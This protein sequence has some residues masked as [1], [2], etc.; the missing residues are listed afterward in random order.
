ML[1]TTYL[2]KWGYLK[3]SPSPVIARQWL[4]PQAIC[5]ILSPFSTLIGCGINRS[6]EFPCPSLPKSPLKIIK[7]PWV[8]PRFKSIENPGSR[9]LAWSAF[10]QKTNS[11][12]RKT[13]QLCCWFTP[14]NIKENE[15]ARK[16]NRRTRRNL[17][18]KKWGNT[19]KVRKGKML[20]KK[21]RREREEQQD[22][23][24]W[25]QDL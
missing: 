22:K 11:S 25:E 9:R 15:K 5:R 21:G 24:L 23:E 4:S 18:K 2:G 8:Q 3:T 13:T 16:P 1:R 10:S 19:R 14:Q 12:N 17:K 20:D 7:H 6:V